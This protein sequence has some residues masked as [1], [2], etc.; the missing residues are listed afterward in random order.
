MGYVSEQD[1]AFTLLKSMQG[2]WVLFF[3]GTI[4][5]GLDH[6]LT[7]GSVTL[8]SVLFH[9]QGDSAGV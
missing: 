1:T 2:S 5:M 6:S 3:L 4:I 8:K 9:L 7:D